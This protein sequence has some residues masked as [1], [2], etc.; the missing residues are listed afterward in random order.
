M[1]GRSVCARCGA[2]R[3]H[4]RDVC[5]G[6]GDRPEGEAIAVAWLLSSEHLDDRSLD[7]AAERIRRGEPLRPSQ[8]SLDQARRA[9]GADVST[10][11][12][13]DL[14]ER[15]LL[16]AVS[17]LLTPLPAW[18]AALWW[19]R[20]RPRAAIQAFGLAVVGTVAF[21]GLWAAVVFG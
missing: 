2:V 17:L 7:A 1:S 6:C 3:G 12:G 5:A 4:F 8:S 9:V 20:E 14:R 21:A 10:D 16:L 15:I 11:P 13:L 18:T 19:R